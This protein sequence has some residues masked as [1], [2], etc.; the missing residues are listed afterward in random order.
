MLKIS[1]FLLLIICFFN[2][3]Y[4]KEA[5]CKLINRSLERYDGEIHFVQED[6][7]SPTRIHGKFVNNKI[8]DLRGFHV[9][10][11]ADFSN[12][13]TSA[14]PH[15]N[16]FNK[17]HGSP[18]DDERHVGDMGNLRPDKAGNGVIDYEDTLITLFG[19]KSIIG[20]ACVVHEKEDD[21]GRG[22]TENS[23]KT[24]DAGG[25]L[26]CGEIVEV[27]SESHGFFSYLLVIALALVLYYF[28]VVR[29]RNRYMQMKDDTN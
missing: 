19:D 7:N 15:Y 18:N 5:V 20:R 29:R 25:R 11:H 28:C 12:G 16:P 14:G 13:C 27:I 6:E 26:A 10:E 21:L 1:H 23:K 8:E 3:V 4:S 22:G 9:H 2:C 24:G 17:L